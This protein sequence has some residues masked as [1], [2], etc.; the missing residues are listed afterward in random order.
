MKLDQ[1]PDENAQN[2]FHL[3]EFLLHKETATEENITQTPQKCGNQVY[4]EKLL[5]SIPMLAA[6]QN[7]KERDIG[8]TGN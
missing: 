6:K 8:N 1:H 3:E 2:D 5:L 7:D 4:E